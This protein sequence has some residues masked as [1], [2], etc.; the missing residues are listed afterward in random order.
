MNDLT[1]KLNELLNQAIKKGEIAGANLLVMKD[2]KEIAY[3]EAGY[4]SVEKNRPFKRDTI[5]RI[6]SMSKPVTSAAAMILVERGMLEMG[7]PVGDIL[8]EFK[9]QKVWKNGE[10]VPARRNMLVKDLLCMTSGMS[11]GGGDAAGQEVWR[12]LEDMDKRLYTD[13][14]MTTMEFAAKIGGCGLSFNPGEQ[15]MYGTSADILGAVIQKVTGMSYG[16]FLKKEIFEPLGMKDTGFFISEDKKDRV[17]DVYEKTSEGIRLYETNHL[18]IRYHVSFEP[19]AFESGG[20]GL[21]STVDDYSRFATMLLQ[22]GEYEGKRIL[23]PETVSFMTTGKLLPWQQESLWKSWD[24]MAGYT[25]GNLLRVMENPGMAYFMTW[26]GEYGWDGWLG[27]YFCNS[28]SNKV[29]ILMSCQRRDGGTM[30]V[31]K[32][33][34][35][36]IGANIEA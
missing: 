19:P 7:Q 6:Y 35:N 3:T 24:A 29:T 8:E 10:K 9:N 22:G 20:A 1:A 23:Q 14:A 30:D 28:P 2:G 11:Y 32:R 12:V 26:K 17:A 16:E 36:V 21:L 34:R 15:W 27:T 13:N 5:C 18:G 25:Y 33:I 31:T 4:A